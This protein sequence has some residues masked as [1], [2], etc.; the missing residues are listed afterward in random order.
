MAN[1][2]PRWSSLHSMVH[3]FVHFS[4]ILSC[5]HCSGS[6][7]MEKWAMAIPTIN[8]IRNYRKPTAD[9]APRALAAIRREDKPIDWTDADPDKWSYRKIIFSGAMA[10]KKA[11]ETEEVTLCTPSPQQGGLLP[12]IILCIHT[13][14]GF[15]LGHSAGPRNHHVRSCTTQGRPCAVRGIVLPDQYDR[16]AR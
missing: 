1:P 5:D 6:Q 8:A 10:F 12:P 16:V 14:L 2:T 13:K 15:K 11:P 7:G 9:K 4:V 3:A